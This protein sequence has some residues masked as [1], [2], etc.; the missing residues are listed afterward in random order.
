MDK[1]GYLCFRKR[2]ITCLSTTLWAEGRSIAFTCSHYI[3]PERNAKS[4]PKAAK[5]KNERIW[6]QKWCQKMQLDVGSGAI[7]QNTPRFRCQKFFEISESPFFTP[8]DVKNGVKTGKRRQIRC[9]N[10]GM[11][12]DLVPKIVWFSRYVKKWR[13]KRCQNMDIRLKLKKWRQ[14]RCQ[15]MPCNRNQALP[16]G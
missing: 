6:R 3:R 13:Q 1:S 15:N 5:W 16:G 8:N 9:Q 11:T 7:F 12:S 14:N 4:R 10:S 2:L